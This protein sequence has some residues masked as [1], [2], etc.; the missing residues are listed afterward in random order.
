MQLANLPALVVVTL[1]DLIWRAARGLGLGELGRSFASRWPFPVRVKITGG[2]QMYVDL[3]SRIG[4]GL[5][6]TGTFDI[7]AIEPAL[8]ALGP[9][10]TFID[11]GANV[12]FYSLLALDCVGPAGR[13]YCFEID[14]RP[15][16]ALRKTIT[17]FGIENI[18]LNEVAVA[19]E[20]STSFFVPGVDHGHTRIDQSAEDGYSVA[21]VRLDTWAKQRS[22]TR[23]DVMKIDV[24][25][26]EKLVLEGAYQTIM[27]YR[28]VIVCEA[29]ECSENFDY[30]IDDL[31]ALFQSLD[32]ETEWLEGVWTPTLLAKP[33]Q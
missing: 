6:A 31:I 1:P 8:K 33:K 5:F 16:R 23:V 25:G 29:C 21:T 7:A 4:E 3:R 27:K 2:R 19:D 22:L 10:A 17:T 9:G 20:D 26:A 13:V 11:I 15:L 12:G 14:P 30:S 32:Y 24:E 18:E 28:P